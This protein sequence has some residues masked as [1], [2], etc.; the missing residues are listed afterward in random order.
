TL[1]QAIVRFGLLLLLISLFVSSV[2]AQALTVTTIAGN[3]NAGFG[4]DGGPATAASLGNPMGVSVDGAGNVYIADTFNHRIRKVSIGGVIT[5][6]AGNGT[7][8]YSGD[9][10]VAVSGRVDNPVDGA[11][12]SIGSL[13]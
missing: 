3:G 12:D 6:F 5:T 1:M 4:G 13:V 9:G 2:H 11:S 7:P 8:G 10:D